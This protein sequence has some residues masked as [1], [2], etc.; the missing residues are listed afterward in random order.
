MRGYPALLAQCAD[1]P[2]TLRV[3]GELRPEDERA[4][5]VVGTRAMTAYGER[6]TRELVGDLARAGITV[7]SGLAHGIDE[8]AHRAALDAGGRTLAVLGCGLRAFRGSVGRRRLFDRIA[9]H[10][11]LLSEYEDDMPAREWTFPQRNRI[12]AGLA[13]ATVVVEAGA[14]SGALITAARALDYD[15]SVFAIPA[16][17][18]APKSVGCHR[19]IA[20]GRARLCRG[21]AD[22]LTE[23]G[24]IL[25]PAALPALPL[26]PLE[27]AIVEA[28]GAE[29]RHMDEIAR[30]LQRPVDEIAAT[31]T[32]LELRDAVRCIGDGRFIG[33]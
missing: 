7:V 24:V 4:V 29:A 2:G 28:V 18:Y 10:G 20:E 23:L 27:R 1:A 6:V 17:L 26:S 19:L 5:A 15:R 8:V 31:L 12:I 22:V 16:S 30:A 32:L 21:A 25:G 33:R 11:A 3:R 14:P 9:Q 13:L